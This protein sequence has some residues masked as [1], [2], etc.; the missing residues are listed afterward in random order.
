MKFLPFDLL[1]PVGK[2]K[3]SGAAPFVAPCCR[4]SMLRHVIRSISTKNR[5]KSGIGR[6]LHRHGHSY[7][8]R[9]LEQGDRFPQFSSDPLSMESSGCLRMCSPSPTNPPPPF[10]SQLHSCR[11]Y[12]MTVC[13]CVTKPYIGKHEPTD[14]AA[15]SVRTCANTNA[16]TLRGLLSP[17]EFVCVRVLCVIACKCECKCLSRLARSRNL[18]ERVLIYYKLVKY[19]DSA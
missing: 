3:R 12:V 7:R 19:A 10:S 11:C 16:G 6:S 9:W 4:A 18:R 14:H 2:T 5:D 17:L 15:P 13:V 8:K 1:R